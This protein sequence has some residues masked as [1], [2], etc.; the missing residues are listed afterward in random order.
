MQRLGRYELIRV[1]GTGGQG[2][3][4]EAVLTGPGGFRKPVAL[5]R[6]TGPG[7]LPREARLGGLL[8][9]A[10]LVEV[11]ALET[12]DDDWVCA[13]E[14][15]RGG[16]LSGHHLPPKA[17]VEVGLQVCAALE[18]AHE[19]LGMVH[20]DLK[21]ANLLLDGA[22]VKVADLGLSTGAGERA[23]GG[24]QGYMAPEQHAR[25]L[26][27]ARTDVFALGVVLTELATGVRPDGG[28][29]VTVGELDAL[30]LTHAPP[31]W[32]LPIV[33]RCCAPR[34]DHRFPS[35]EAVAD[36]L[37]ALSVTGA[38]LADA[39]ELPTPP[40]HTLGPSRVTNIAHDDPFM[41]RTAELEQLREALERAGAVTLKGTAGIGKTRL[42]REAALAWHRTHSGE[43]WFC[44]LTVR[45]D[46]AHAV[47]TTLGIDRRRLF[48]VLEERSPI[49]L[50]LDDPAEW[51][52]VTRLARIPGVSI[53]ATSRE[54]GPG[55]I[56]L[57]P[58]S[59][60][61][62]TDLL[63]QRSGHPPT[64]ELHELAV[65]LDGNPLAIELAARRL[66][67]MSAEQMLQRLHRR[68]ALL[69]GREQL[70]RASIAVS[71]N[72]L[73][74]TERS[75][76]SQ[77]AVF[78][79]DFTVEAADAVLQ[80]D[81]RM[82][83]LDVL[84]SLVD[85]SM[86]QGRDGRL[87]LDANVGAFAREHLA[88]PADTERRHGAW[89]AR[90]TPTEKRREHLA[91]LLVGAR[92][93]IERGEPEL[94]V[95]LC[96]GVWNA[97]KEVGPIEPLRELAT[98]VLALPA[99][100]PSQRGAA[101]RMLANALQVQGRPTDAVPH[102]EQA[103]HAL[104]GTIDGVAARS[105][106]ARALAHL[107]R[108]EATTQMK[109][110]LADAQA[111]D[112]AV[113][114]AA[115]WG[116]L[117][118]LHMREARLDDALTA[119]RTALDHNRKLGRRA[120][121]G[122]VLG[123]LGMLLWRMGAYE[124]ARQRYTEALAIHRALGNRL[125]EADTLANLGVLCRDAGALQDARTHLMAA[126]VLHDVV[127]NRRS[128]GATQMNLALVLRD[129]GALDEA[130]SLLEQATATLHVIGDPR[131]TAAVHAKMG[132]ILADQGLVD[133]AILAVREAL[134][135]QREAGDVR[136]QAV[137]T[138]TLAGLVARQGHP[139]EARAL[140]ASAL[141]LAV[142]SGHRLA[143]FAAQIQLGALDADAALLQQ[144][145]DAVREVGHPVLEG[146]AARALGQL[147]QDPTLIAHAL[148]CHAGVDREL[149][150]DHLALG[151]L[152]GPD[153]RQHLEHAVRLLANRDHDAH[154][155]ARVVLDAMPV[156]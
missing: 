26:V 44:D 152:G 10:N 107:S 112:D 53:I 90:D 94:A 125:F 38:G 52:T 131:L 133:R 129:L 141:Q 146:K 126:L 39:I 100:E 135:T 19:Q 50:V 85:R 20:A 8:R 11:Y 145:L 51:E 121:E 117:A 14:L 65:Q 49:V 120:S 13:M 147:R 59:P 87:H 119:Y 149:G 132:V 136:G 73:E 80:L 83:T 156:A 3:V 6:L 56:E 99:L 45:I 27:D 138:A 81:P 7:D 113:G 150:V 63:T 93:A 134:T 78:V 75:A 101:L 143:G 86:L 95:G 124:P 1:L 64:P 23:R 69:G 76:L 30:P 34:P 144:T 114:I 115:S 123:N 71:W 108:P 84:Q 96:R 16:T 130:R 47:A 82:F 137:N 104:T 109:R 62:T 128:F 5:K 148:V 33:E 98:S 2:T 48:D 111:L 28:A 60:Q 139:I 110:A 22:T 118:W 67:H 40:S 17:V 77:C 105:D 24:T 151:K 31:D 61:T 142:E 42:A 66:A 92:R 58:L 89:F 122:A 29:T 102:L 41:G 153:A 72:A 154:E 18:H 155:Q 103:V 37:A 12:I 57:G 74:P 54:R 4:Y 35:M 68:V 70:L 91:D 9:H 55:V 127:G 116:N 97:L 21:P 43:A 140:A 15:V 79:G 32:L 25:E 88:E 36:A 106:L 46:M